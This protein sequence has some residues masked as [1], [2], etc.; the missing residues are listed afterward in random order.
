[1][2]KSLF[3]TNQRL[4]YKPNHDFLVAAKIV[5]LSGIQRSQQDWLIQQFGTEDK[6]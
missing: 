3:G 6:E 4:H 2:G 5:D 1:M